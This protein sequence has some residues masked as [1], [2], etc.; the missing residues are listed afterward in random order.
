ME[1][2]PGLSKSVQDRT[3]YLNLN[4][5]VITTYNGYLTTNTHHGITKNNNGICIDTRSDSGLTTEA[6]TIEVNGGQTQDTSLRIKH[7]DTS[8]L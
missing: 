4:D 1:L 7:P 5:E 3:L 2:G 8:G 6:R